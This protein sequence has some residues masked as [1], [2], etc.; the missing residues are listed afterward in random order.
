MRAGWMRALG[1]MVAA[2]HD[3]QATP[4][5]VTLLP[6]K[7]PHINAEIASVNAGIWDLARSTNTSLLDAHGAFVSVRPVG[8]LFRQPNGFTDGLHP[9]DGGYK[10]LAETIAKA[11]QA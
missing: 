6:T 8:S 4:I 3:V 11:L 7:D 1:Q 9:N 10:Q 2:V 5:L